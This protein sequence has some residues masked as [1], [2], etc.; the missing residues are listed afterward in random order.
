MNAGF[1]VYF[2]FRGILYLYES[3]HDT[4]SFGVSSDY[5]CYSRI[6]NIE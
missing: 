4:G 3:T 6:A 5:I 1:E 2:A